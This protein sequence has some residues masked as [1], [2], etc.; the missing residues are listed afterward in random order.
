MNKK[1]DTEYTCPNCGVVVS[2]PE[3]EEDAMCDGCKKKVKKD[4]CGKKKKMDSANRLDIHDLDWEYLSTK[5]EETPEGYLKGTACVTNI[6]AF[7]Y[8]MAD[9]TIVTELRL[10]E[11]VM[12]W[13]S[14]QTLTLK[15]VTFGHPSVG[16]DAENIKKLEVG[17][18]GS[19]V[20]C[21]QDRVYIDFVVTDKATI[22]A[23]KNG[24]RALSCGYSRDLEPVSGRHNGQAYDGIQRNIR[25]NHLAIVDRG[26]AGD[27]AVMRLD[28]L[29]DVGIF[30]SSK[31]KTMV[32]LKLDKAEF[33]V[34]QAVVDAFVAL[35]AK[36]DSSSADLAKAQGDLKT[37]QDSITAVTA[38]RDTLKGA[39]EALDGEVKALKAKADAAP[40]DIKQAV[41]DHLALVSKVSA[42][43]VE[44][45]GDEDTA[46][47]RKAV[48]LKVNPKADLTDKSDAYITAAYDLAISMLEGAIAQDQANADEM[49]EGADKSKKPVT[50]KD[51]QAKQ[52]SDIETAYQK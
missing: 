12:D 9:G 33:E 7:P 40:A 27:D 20:F 52:D 15:P 10:R 1:K 5:F 25:Y 14:L 30:K 41:K 23:I 4:E 3:G 44:L 37:A 26:R 6:G 51:A 29:D 42:L 39:K 45:K 47:I 49:R 18:T 13:E 32:K 50:S 11:D 31:E 43:K 36:A 48:I 16:V 19:H 34:E 35:Q 28:G 2:F 38:E 8:R 17:M 22:T 46:G 21:D 24:T